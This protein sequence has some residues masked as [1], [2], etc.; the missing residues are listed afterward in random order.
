MLT[1]VE[2]DENLQDVHTARRNVPRSM[3]NIL[4]TKNTSFC[5]LILFL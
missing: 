2:M 3:A 5:Q 1:K 4:W